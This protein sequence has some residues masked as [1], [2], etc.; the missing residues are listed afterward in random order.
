VNVIGTFITPPVAKFFGAWALILLRFIMGCGQGVLVPCM[1]VLIAHWFPL[2]E[3]STAIAIATTGNQFS[4]IVAM[5]ATAELCQIIG[6]PFAFYTYG[7]IYM[8]PFYLKG[9]SLS[10][11]L[12]LSLSLGLGLGLSPSLSLSHSDISKTLKNFPDAI[13]S[14]LRGVSHIS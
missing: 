11:G 6:W 14:T 8:L 9:L 10:L 5:F 12:G 1:N 4:V 2:A 3:K 13:S 7:R